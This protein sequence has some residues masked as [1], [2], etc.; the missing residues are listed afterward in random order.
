MVNNTELTP[1]G[2]S[3]PEVSLHQ[4][5]ARSSRLEFPLL[6]SRLFKASSGLFVFQVTSSVNDMLPSGSEQR[7]P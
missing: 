2:S 5:P 1:G 6:P 3:G 4:A 7:S